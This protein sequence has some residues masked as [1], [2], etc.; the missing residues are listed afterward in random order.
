MTVYIW[1]ARGRGISGFLSRWFL[2]SPW[3]RVGLSFDGVYIYESI[4]NL[5]VT[6]RTIERF[7]K[8]VDVRMKYELTVP[9][10]EALRSFIKSNLISGFNWWRFIG[11]KG[12]KQ[13][14]QTNYIS[15]EFVY[16][17][18]KYSG[19]TIRPLALIQTPLYFWLAL[20]CARITR[21]T[22]EVMYS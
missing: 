22:P 4:P 9:N 14:N 8:G 2:S 17:A 13:Y 7:E 20:V 16:D 1:F 3:D 11:F 10:P 19:I 18:I 6:I 5:G 21:V 15:S 12:F